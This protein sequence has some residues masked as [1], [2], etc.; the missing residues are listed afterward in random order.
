[1]E[2]DGRTVSGGYRFGYQNQE[3]DDEVKGEG[4]IYD[5]G[6]RMYDPR[7]GNFL[8]LDPMN[9]LFVDISRYSF[10]GNNPNMFVDY[11]GMFKFPA[12]ST[13]ETDY[14]LLTNYLKNNIA[15]ILNSPEIMSALSTY[16][17]L[18]SAEVKAALVWGEGPTIKITELESRNGRFI[19]NIHS[20]ELLLNK[21][22]VDNLEKALAENKQANLLLVTSTILHEFTH[23]GDDQDGSDYPG[24]EGT[25]FEKAVFGD[26]IDCVADAQDVLLKVASGSVPSSVTPTV[27]SGSSNFTVNASGGNLNLRSAAG[28]NKSVITS[29]VNGTLVTGTGKTNGLWKEVTTTEGTKGWVHSSYITN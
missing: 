11:E 12:G 13:F 20:D 27:S 4:N 16:G 2:L 28:T 10:A 3:K 22:I 9:R 24:E 8:S 25:E 18:T 7:I 29:L 15:E 21:E 19:S 26:D 23:Y 1:V 17:Q 5:F 6:A 14:P